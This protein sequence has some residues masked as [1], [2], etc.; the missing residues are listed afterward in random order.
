MQVPTGKVEILYKSRGFECGQL[1]PQCSLLR[2]ANQR[3]ISTVRST[4]ACSP[5]S[6]GSSA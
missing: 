1:Q 2:I 5:H 3:A 4:S 6:K